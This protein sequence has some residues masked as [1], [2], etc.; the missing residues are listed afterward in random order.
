MAGLAEPSSGKREWPQGRPELAFVFQEPTLMPW[1]SVAANA[2]L[3]LLLEGI[4]AEERRGRAQAALDAVGL[5]AFASAY[6]R[7]L[8]G[9]MKM[10]VS[11]AR[12]LA[13]RPQALLLDEPFAALDETTREELND[14]LLEL[15]RKERFASV[16]VTHSVYESV[17]LSTRIL[18]LSA[19]PARIVAEFTNTDDY[20]RP[21][22]Y[23]MSLRYNALVTEVR[24]ALR[25]ASGAEAA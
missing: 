20:P 14:Q 12:A 6:P 5:G 22:D 13:T 7:E 8:S 23:R 25:R 17:Y 16:F 24:A 15:W 9:G 1:A 11:L 10:R 2:E 4:G 19:R 21:K 3:P 18:V